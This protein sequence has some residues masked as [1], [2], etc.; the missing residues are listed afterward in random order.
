MGSQKSL[1]IY[2]FVL[3][4]KREIPDESPEIR[5]FPGLTSG[6]ERLREMQNAALAE[7]I[8]P[9]FRQRQNIFFPSWKSRILVSPKRKRGRRKKPDRMYPVKC[10]GLGP[11]II[12]QGERGEALPCHNFRINLLKVDDSSFAAIPFYF[13]RREMVAFFQ[14]KPRSGGTI[15]QLPPLLSCRPHCAVWSRSLF[16]GSRS[17]CR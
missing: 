15:S 4:I 2:A 5:L 14:K 6:R 1:Q 17:G 12:F 13:M 3:I 9:G 16:S 10:A 11:A 7:Y 8:S